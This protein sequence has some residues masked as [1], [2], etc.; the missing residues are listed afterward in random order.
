L[1]TSAVGR[2]QT[3]QNPRSIAIPGSLPPCPF[4]PPPKKE[5]NFSIK[6]K[7]HFLVEV[8]SCSKNIADNREQKC[9]KNENVCKS[10]YTS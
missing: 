10:K 8:H 4:L 2:D 3:A 9:K 7:L 5:E 1:S 6:N